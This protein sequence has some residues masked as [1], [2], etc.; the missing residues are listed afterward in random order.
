MN[1][2]KKKERE[3]FYRVMPPQKIFEHTKGELQQVIIKA[4][5]EENEQLKQALRMPWEIILPLWVMF[6]VGMIIYGITISG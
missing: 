3:L 1:K 6:F 4:W 2:E 5:K